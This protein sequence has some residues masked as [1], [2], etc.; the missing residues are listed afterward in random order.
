MVE[1]NLAD[2]AHD[3]VSRRRI[4][5][6]EDTWFAVY[7]DSWNERGA[8]WKFGQGTMYL[9]PDVP[10]VILGSQFVYDLDLG[11]YVYGFAFN[12]EPTAYKVTAPHPATLFTPE[13]LAARSLR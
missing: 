2:G 7:S 8:L 1:G 5:L 10:A 13:S 4:Y 3:I 11:G 12:G 6:D 9:M